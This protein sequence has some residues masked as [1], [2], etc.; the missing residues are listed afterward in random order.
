MKKRGK[1]AET[2]HCATHTHVYIYASTGY[3]DIK[4]WHSKR[5]THWAMRVYH[6]SDTHHTFNETVK[7]QIG[8]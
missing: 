3:V 2:K 1:A 6:K 5:L 4:L 8:N 7:F